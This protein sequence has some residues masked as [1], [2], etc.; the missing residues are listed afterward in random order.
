MLG[1]AAAAA[2]VVADSPALAE[3]ALEA[4][5]VDRERYALP[6]THVAETVRTAPETIVPIVNVPPLACTS[7]ASRRE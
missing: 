5:E 1:L 3:D 7:S 2:V 6:L 4:I